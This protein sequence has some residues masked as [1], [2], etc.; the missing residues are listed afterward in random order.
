[1]KRRHWVIIVLVLLFGGFS[2]FTYSGALTPYVTFAEAR[3][4]S[5]TVQ[6]RGVLADGRIESV[7]GGKNIRFLLR[8]DQG[9]E[10]Y[11]L[12]R[13]I[14]PEGMETATSVVAIGKF[15][16]GQFVSD[17]LL[18]KCPSKY[19]TAQGGTNRS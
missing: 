7:E 9:M 14:K 5:G 19:Q 10:A 4:N 15:R 2:A 16:D 6:V 1:M 18:V 3:K 11:V 8:D 13:G 12:Y 17:K